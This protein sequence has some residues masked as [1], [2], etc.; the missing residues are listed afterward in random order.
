MAS[1]TPPEGPEGPQEDA[2]E[3]FNFDETYRSVTGN[4]LELLPSIGFSANESQ[5]APR[6]TVLKG[7]LDKVLH[8]V[9][10]SD[11]GNHQSN[12]VALPP[13]ALHER[14]TVTRLRPMLLSDQDMDRLRQHRKQVRRDRRQMCWACFLP[15]RARNNDNHPGVTRDIECIDT[16]T[17][18]H[19]DDVPS[20]APY[21]NIEGL[22]T[23]KSGR[24]SAAHRG[25]TPILI[26]TKSGLYHRPEHHSFPYM[27]AQLPNGRA[28]VR[29]PLQR[30]N[31]LTEEPVT[32]SYR[33]LLNHMST[34]LVKPDTLGTSLLKSATTKYHTALNLPSNQLNYFNT[35]QIT[36]LKM[37][38][39][40]PAPTDTDLSQDFDTEWSLAP[41]SSAVVKYSGIGLAPNE[42]R[43]KPMVS[44]EYAGPAFNQR[45]VSILWYLFEEYMMFPSR[46]N[47][48][49]EK[50]LTVT[51][52]F[53]VNYAFW[54]YVGALLNTLVK[55][56]WLFDY[57][58]VVLTEFPKAAVR[59]KTGIS[60]E[61]TYVSNALLSDALRAVR[62]S[63]YLVC[64]LFDSKHELQEVV[65]FYQPA[66]GHTTGNG[67]GSISCFNQILELCKEEEGLGPA[68][69]LT[70]TYV[71][72]RIR[73]RAEMVQRLIHMR[74]HDGDYF[75]VHMI[76]L[77][78]FSMLWLKLV[79]LQDEKDTPVDE[80]NDDTSAEDIERDFENERLAKALA[81]NEA[82]T[83]IALEHNTTI[84]ML[85]FQLFPE[86]NTKYP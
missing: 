54:E 42:V 53:K 47:Q 82:R 61:T 52:F 70:L 79:V 24:S 31:Y 83:V 15:G 13:R 80:E 30:S 49:T 18:R 39:I 71:F 40:L 6:S 2:S 77:R 64:K 10:G 58:N 48:L 46:T 59:P 16:P 63:C 76:N 19:I 25:Y 62:T 17:P 28:K 68:C 29:L 27:T 45:L 51:D 12:H 26:G 75:R 67:S 21:L 14:K 34:N 9:S 84:R 23:P 85:Y 60:S 4:D 81:L 36:P 22:D 86:F 38:G 73:V 33:V 74:E 57:L 41:Q 3:K 11:L 20:H 32:D 69:R 35:G 72:S 5:A 1:P 55:R 43:F 50:E 78:C 56:Y 65:R 7:F 66:P 8:A 37:T 44:F